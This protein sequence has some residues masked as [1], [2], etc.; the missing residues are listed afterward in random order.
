M[1]K[2]ASLIERAAKVI[3]DKYHKIVSQKRG[4]GTHIEAVRRD[5][6]N[7][8]SGKGVRGEGGEGEGGEGRGT[9]IA[10]ARTLKKKKC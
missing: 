7:E 3:T 6:E 8:D 2:R 4:W 9:T 10:R 5:I 1:F